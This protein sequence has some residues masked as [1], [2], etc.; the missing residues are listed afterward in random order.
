[1]PSLIRLN[2]TYVKGSSAE[3]KDLLS[4]MINWDV[5]DTDEIRVKWDRWESSN[6]LSEGWIHTFCRPEV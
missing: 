5:H 6:S 3:V 1:M 4:K 2:I